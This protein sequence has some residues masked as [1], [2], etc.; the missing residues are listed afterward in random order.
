MKYILIVL[1]GILGLVPSY[2]SAV[3]NP[4]VTVTKAEGYANLPYDGDVLILVEFK[5]DYGVTF[6]SEGIDETFTVRLLSGSNELSSFIPFRRLKG[7]PGTTVG[8]ILQNGG[9][10]LSVGSFYFTES[11]ALSLGLITGSIT[12]LKV[13]VQGSPLVFPD[14]VRGSGIVTEIFPILFSSNLAV[15]LRDSIE[16][17]SQ[18][19]GS[20][21][22]LGIIQVST[23]GEGFVFTSVGHDYFVSTVRILPTILPGIFTESVGVPEFIGRDQ[24]TTYRDSRLALLNGTPIKGLGNALEAG[25]VWV[26]PAGLIPSVLFTSIFWLGVIVFPVVKV[27]MKVTQQVSASIIVGSFLAGL[28][29]YLGFIP[30]EFIAMAVALALVWIV[31]RSWLSRV[32]NL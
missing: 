29:T 23:S 28:G 3:E 21:W 25:E 30:G 22:G 2:L 17:S 20:D 7:T 16:D 10:E 24:N 12:G 18:R 11:E 13:V 32:T 31:M 6:P 5:V 9:Y 19:L 1:I 27:V 4:T 15:K 8:G 26:V 14:T